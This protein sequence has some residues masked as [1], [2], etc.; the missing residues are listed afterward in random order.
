MKTT[1][2]KIEVMQ[3]HDDGGTVQAFSNYHNDWVDVNN[4]K[5]DW[6]T[7]IYRKKPEEQTTD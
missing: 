4:P 6:Y 7:T 1:K 3:H 5:W 2:E